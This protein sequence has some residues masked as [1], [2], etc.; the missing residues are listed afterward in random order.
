MFTV[1]GA[2]LCQF[3]V[4]PFRLHFEGATFQRLLDKVIGT[5]LEEVAFP[6]LDDVILLSETFA[7]NIKLLRDVFSRLRSAG[8]K[9]NVE[10]YKFC[11]CRLELV[12]L[13]TW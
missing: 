3:K 12:Y 4:T 10:K 1:P 8:L 6:Y 13:A 7:E 9:L 2:G 5:D 11:C